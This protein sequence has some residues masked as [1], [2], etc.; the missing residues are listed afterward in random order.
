MASNLLPVRISTLSNADAIYEKHAGQELLKV[1]GG[2]DRVFWLQTGRL[3]CL[4]K[5]TGWGTVDRENQHMSGVWDF[6]SGRVEICGMEQSCTDCMAAAALGESAEDDAFQQSV[7]S[8]QAEKKICSALL[9]DSWLFLNS[10]KVQAAM[11][12]FSMANLRLGFQ[13]R[14]QLK[15]VPFLFFPCYIFCT[16]LHI[17]VV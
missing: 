2:A 9:S 16:S 10:L 17:L 7:S 12:L 6:C 14:L 13:N 5:C 15:N 4:Q 11:G 1:R 8:V 3:S